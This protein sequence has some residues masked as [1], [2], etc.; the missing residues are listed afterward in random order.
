MKFV[1]GD[2]IHEDN[3][4]HGECLKNKNEDI[5]DVCIQSKA[6]ERKYRISD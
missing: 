5:V 3:W 2:V 4:Y 1:E 6:F